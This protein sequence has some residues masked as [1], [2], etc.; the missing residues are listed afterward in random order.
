M[1]GSDEEGMPPASSRRG[2]SVSGSRSEL[3]SSAAEMESASELSDAPKAK[4]KGASGKADRPSLK[5][6]QSSD[7]GRPA[8]SS[9]FLTAAE[10]RAKD[11]KTEKKSGDDPFDFLRDVRDVS[12]ECKIFILQ[13]DT[14]HLMACPTERQ[15]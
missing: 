7:V 8:G 12:H 13:Y 9:S 14:D 11:K 4:K 1:D 3:G 2:S 5:K 10:Q 6:V 15:E